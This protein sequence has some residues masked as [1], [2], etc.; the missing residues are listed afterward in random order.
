MLLGGVAMVTTIMQLMWGCPRRPLSGA[1]CHDTAAPVSGKLH[2]LL[3][4]FRAQIE[5]LVPALKAAGSVGPRYNLVSH[6]WGRYLLRMA[7]TLQCWFQ[8]T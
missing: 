1:V 5:V 6:P 3:P 4:C 2:W 8:P 7:G